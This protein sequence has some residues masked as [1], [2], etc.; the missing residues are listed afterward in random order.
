MRG[1]MGD[2]LYTVCLEQW[3]SQA[4][5]TA[6]TVCVVLLQYLSPLAAILTLHLLIANFLR[7]RIVSEGCAR[8]PE[9]QWRRKRRRHRKNLC[10]LTSMAA[11]FAVAWLPLHIVN[12]LASIDYMVSYTRQWR[13]G[14]VI[15]LIGKL[16]TQP[17]SILH[18]CLRG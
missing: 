3:P 10:L 6:Y 1:F 11:S 16:V 17:T 12:A 7:M 15:Q 18:R 4:A 9:A 14:L 5:L 13:S 2:V 8:L